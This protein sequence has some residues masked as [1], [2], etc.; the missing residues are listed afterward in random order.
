MKLDQIELR[1]IQMPLVSFFETSFGRTTQRRIILVRIFSEGVV[2]WGEATSPEGPFY[3]HESTGT[4]WHIL[5]DFVIPR[6][7]QTPIQSPPDAAVLL[8]PIRGHGMAKAA[9]EI[10]LWD[11][12]ARQSG[13]PLHQLLGGSRRSI[14]CGVSIGIQQSIGELLKKVEKEIHA[15]YQ[16]IKIKIKPGWD[17]D[18]VREVRRQFPASLLMCDANSA[19][20]LRDIDL[21]KRLDEFKLMMIEQPLAWND[22][23]DHIQLQ[24]AIQT[25]ICLDE[26][27]LDAEDARK[28]IESD[29][30]RIINIKLGRVAGHTEAK[31]VHDVC[32]AHSIPVWCGGMLEAGIGRAHNIAMSA[33]QNFS[34]PGDVSASKRYFHRDII[35][36][37]VEVDSQ[38]RIQ[39]LDGPGIGFE[40][41][42]QR[43]DAVTVR[44]EMLRP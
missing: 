25:P 26:S 39:L 24:R 34:L 35:D 11:L 9:A 30:C 21:F 40:P 43:I 44:T 42:L 17:L 8:K 37:E 38:G 13:K 27:I 32:A 14:D 28:A 1:E 3:N 20:T 4:A 22:I 5:R 29:A 19:Y 16:R 12:R 18:V 6:V 23:I 36:P 7:L 15:G 41:N 33:L 2:G 31:R 10:A